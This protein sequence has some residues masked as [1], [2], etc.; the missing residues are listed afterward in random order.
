MKKCIELT[1]DYDDLSIKIYMP[2][3]PFIQDSSHSYTVVRKLFA[4]KPSLTLIFL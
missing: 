4:F 3:Q 1:N 2:F